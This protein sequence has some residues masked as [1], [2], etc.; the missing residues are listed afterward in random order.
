[1]LISGG[2]LNIQHLKLCN[3]S[4]KYKTDISAV[5]KSKIVIDKIGH[6]SLTLSRNIL[7][8]KMF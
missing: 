1:M 3:T 2:A 8:L 6:V 7:S 4:Y 5:F